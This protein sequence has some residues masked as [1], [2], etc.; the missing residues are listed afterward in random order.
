MA[1]TRMEVDEDDEYLIHDLHAKLTL[2]I[3]REVPHIFVW[4]QHGGGR[5]CRVLDRHHLNADNLIHQK[6]SAHQHHSNEIIEACLL[7][8]ETV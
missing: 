6:E 2:C 4:P 8:I 1:T 5:G 3:K 7:V